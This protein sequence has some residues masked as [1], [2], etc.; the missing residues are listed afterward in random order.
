MT[1]HIQEVVGTIQRAPERTT[2]APPAGGGGHGHGA[3][4][5]LSEESARE[6]FKREARL[7]ERV[8]AD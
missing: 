6:F 7:A 4:P 5:S 8:Q 3:E 1:V 2:G